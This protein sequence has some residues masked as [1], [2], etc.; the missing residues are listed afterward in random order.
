MLT[1]MDL[2]S[3]NSVE[4]LRSFLQGIEVPAAP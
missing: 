1:F 4:M 2:A 3:A